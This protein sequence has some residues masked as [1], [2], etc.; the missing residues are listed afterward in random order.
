MSTTPQHNIA[1][2]S[3]SHCCRFEDVISPECSFLKL[4]S[5]D[6]C[7]CTFLP[8]FVHV[9]DTLNIGFSLTRAA[10]VMNWKKQV[11]QMNTP[12]ALTYL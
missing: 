3:S 4:D 7:L 10:Q 12:V 9:I 8:K 5:K 2:D 11:M 1:E 6:T